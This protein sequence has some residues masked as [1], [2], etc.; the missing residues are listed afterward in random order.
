MYHNFFCFFERTSPEERNSC[1]EAIVLKVPPFWCNSWKVFT[2]QRRQVSLCS[3]GYI[4]SGNLCSFTQQGHESWLG[5]KLQRNYKW[6]LHLVS[7]SHMTKIKEA[8]MHRNF[9]CVI[10]PWRSNRTLSCSGAVLLKD[11]QDRSLAL[12][13]RVPLLALQ[14]GNG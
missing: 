10:S 4:V 2:Q 14:V 1:L 8:G 13:R 7:Q 5:R 11:N 3:P 6:F 12:Y 9:S